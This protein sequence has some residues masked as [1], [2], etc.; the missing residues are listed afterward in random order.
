MN[1]KPSGKKS[2]GKRPSSKSPTARGAASQKPVGKKPAGK[3]ASGKSPNSRG[4]NGRLR[5]G[6]L[7]QLVL[8]YMRKNKKGAPHTA[9]A[10]G[11]GV[12]RSSGAVA[13]CLERQ[14]KSGAVMLV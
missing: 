10:V 7:D 9:S 6:G 5:P 11:K 1:K 4:G 12:K 14:E 3:R 8:G 2:V 13:N